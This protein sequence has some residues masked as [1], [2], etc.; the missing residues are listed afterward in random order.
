MDKL[1]NRMETELRDKTIE[2]NF[3]MG[4]AFDYMLN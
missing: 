4:K 2:P 1:K 3:G